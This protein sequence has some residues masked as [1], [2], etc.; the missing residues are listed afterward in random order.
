MIDSCK[1]N[2]VTFFYGISPGLDIKYSDQAEID[3]LN[4]KVQQIQ[5]LGCQGFAILWDDIEP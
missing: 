5:A 2:Q 3:L 1:D 4:N